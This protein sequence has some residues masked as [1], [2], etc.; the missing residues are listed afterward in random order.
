ML[1]DRLNCAEG[2]AEAL[3]DQRFDGFG[4]FGVADGVFVVEDFPAAAAN[5][6]RE[7]GIFRHGIAR[8]SFATAHEIG[9]PGS[10]CAGHHGNAIQEIESA[11]FEIL[12]GDVFEGLPAREPAIAI[13]DFHVSGDGADARIGEIADELGDGVGIDDGVGVDG[14]DDFAG[15]GGETVIERGGLA[16]IRLGD[17]SHARVAV[18]FFADEFAG[19][20]HRAVVDHQNFEL[21]IS[22]S[23][24]GADCGD[25][26][27]F[28]VVR[29]DEHAYRRL[30][31]RMIARARAAP[32][33]R[34]RAAR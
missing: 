1:P 31:F 3:A 34:A 12:A 27:G 21:R 4:D 10:D 11:L 24:R 28:L 2:P 19:A 29:G 5:G 30:I 22:G 9:A 7:I 6:D 8:K 23:K 16:A 32:S 14:D 18:E 20:V 15:R 33:R 26:D 13:H 17:E 25:D